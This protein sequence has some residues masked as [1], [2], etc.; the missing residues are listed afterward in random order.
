MTLEKAAAFRPRLIHRLTAGLLCRRFKATL[1]SLAIA[2]R[3]CLNP[4]SRLIP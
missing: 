3:P 1:Q 2:L 4:Y